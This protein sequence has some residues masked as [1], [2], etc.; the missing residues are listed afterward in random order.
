M[1]NWQ[2]TGGN[3]EK[4]FST[5]LGLAISTTLI[6]YIGIFPA[7]AVLRRRL[8]NVARPYKAPV[9]VLI[10]ILLT[11][12]VV[13]SVIQLLMPGLG[14]AWFGDAYRPSAWGA[15]EKWKYLATD[16]VPLALFVLAGVVFWALGAKTRKEIA[17]P[18]PEVV[19][20]PG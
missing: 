4:L 12:L 5:V 14:D 2:I 15:D 18:A 11:A 19:V 1:Q 17:I 13:F 7:L 8:P 3:A 6:S 10:S 16:V 9:P 20:L